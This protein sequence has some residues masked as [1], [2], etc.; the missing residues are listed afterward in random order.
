MK[1]IML[2]IIGV[3]ILLVETF[4]TNFFSGIVSINFLLVFV[5]LV[6]LYYEK[7]YSLILGGILGLINDLITGGV[8]G[9]TGILFLAVS[10]F[11]ASIEKSIFKDD[12][13]IIFFLVY[14]IS[15]GFS[16]INSVVSAIFFVPPSILVAV[17]KML[18]LI[19][20]LNS[21]A[22]VVVYSLFGDQLKKLRED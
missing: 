6:S 20:L 8:M 9:V 13:K 11:I 14:I 7:S 1:K 21:F 10:Y 18:V 4:L 17:V 22:A 3:V 2:F 16:L 12:R 15:V 5:V 19:P